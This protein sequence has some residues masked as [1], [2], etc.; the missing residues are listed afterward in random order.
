MQ[1]RDHEVTRDRSLHRN[2]RRLLVTDLTDHD[3]VG[4]LTQDG[5]QGACKGQVSSG[6]DLDLVDPVDIGLHRILNRDDVDLFLIQCGERR[7]EGRRLTASGRTRHEEDAVRIRNDVIK[8][9]DFL[10]PH[11]K[12]ILRTV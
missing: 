2:L 3:D 7:I 1:G 5:T 11:A 8:L 10:R 12:L 6:V 4:V 9:L